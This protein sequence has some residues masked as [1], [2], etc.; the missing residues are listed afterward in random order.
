MKKQRR[1]KPWALLDKWVSKLTGRAHHFHV[2]VGYKAN[3]SAA[4]AYTLA[5]VINCPTPIGPNFIRQVRKYMGKRLMDDV[6]RHHKNNG[7]LQIM[8]MSY[9]GR[10]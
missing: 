2:K 3:G 10:F 1:H 6:P 8:G 7:H 4:P 9:L 5:M